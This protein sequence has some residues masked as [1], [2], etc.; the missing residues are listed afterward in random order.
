MR[1][2]KENLSPI[3]KS[4]LFYS[5]LLASYSYILRCYF[6]ESYNKFMRCRTKKNY[7]YDIP[8]CRRRNRRNNVIIT[9]GTDTAYVSDFNTNLNI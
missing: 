1:L 5:L 2:K 9:V 6:N 8:A 7:C 4:M 3:Y